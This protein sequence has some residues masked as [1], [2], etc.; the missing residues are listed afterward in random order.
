MPWLY[1]SVL[2][3]C[4]SPTCSLLQVNMGLKQYSYATHANHEPTHRENGH[5]MRCHPVVSQPRPYCMLDTCSCGPHRNISACT[6]RAPL[7]AS[8]LQSHTHVVTVGAPFTE[9]W[10]RYTTQLCPTTPESSLH[11]VCRP[12][13]LL[14]IAAVLTADTCRRNWNSAPR[15]AKT[16]ATHEEMCMYCNVY[17]IRSRIKV[18]SAWNDQNAC[19]PQNSAV[20]LYAHP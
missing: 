6:S 18:H 5:G 1:A 10:T 12:R 2:S 17:P 7:Q 16:S 20:V 4:G 9:S 13:R 14:S 8:G 19:Q 11:T 3:A 15:V